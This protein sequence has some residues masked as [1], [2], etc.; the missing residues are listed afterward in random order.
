VRTILNRKRIKK[1][2]IYSFITFL[3]NLKF[4]KL[5]LNK[6]NFLTISLDFLGQLNNKVIF[7]ISVYLIEITNKLR[8]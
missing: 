8:S 1:F 5:N 7:Y 4:K 2:I 6:F 3:K